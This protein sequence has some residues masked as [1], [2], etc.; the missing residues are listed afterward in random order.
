MSLARSKTQYDQ[1]PLGTVWERQ[2]I[3]QLRLYGL[4]DNPAN[5]FPTFGLLWGIK[6]S[7]SPPCSKHDWTIQRN[8]AY[9]KDKDVGSHKSHD[10]T[11]MSSSKA[12]EE[13]AQTVY[14]NKEGKCVSRS[15][16]LAERGKDRR[17]KAC[18][19]ILHSPVDTGR[20]RTRTLWLE[21]GNGIEAARKGKDPEAGGSG[22]SLSM[23]Y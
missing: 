21:C 10:Q 16:L 20:I 14:R 17:V 15:E 22:H 12:L 9:D 1:N 8:K 6:S 23:S 5:H 4:Y 3:Q 13:A 2:H 7:F 11:K 19:C 18:I